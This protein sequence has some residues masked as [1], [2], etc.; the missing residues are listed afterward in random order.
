M[1]EE[2]KMAEISGLG[3]KKKERKSSGYVVAMLGCKKMGVGNGCKCSIS[4][5]ELISQ[6]V[7]FDD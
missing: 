4:H 7:C 5:L 2:G 3:E 1:V 6:F